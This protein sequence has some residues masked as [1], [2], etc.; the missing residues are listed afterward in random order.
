MERGAWTQPTDLVVVAPFASATVGRVSRQCETGHARKLAP[1][2][3]SLLTEGVR[4][5]RACSRYD[6]EEELATDPDAN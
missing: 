2:T 5:L 3:D 1:G 4:Q 6:P